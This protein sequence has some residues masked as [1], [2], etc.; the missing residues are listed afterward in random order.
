[1]PT[2]N[3]NGIEIYY[4]RHGDRGEPLVLVHGYTGDITDWRHQLPEFSKTHRVLIMDHRGHGRSHAPVDR[5]QY[6]IENM[7]SDVEALIEHAGF[8]RYH[9]LGHSMGG[10]IAQEIAVGS[11][12]RLMSLTLHDTGYRFGLNRNEMVQKWIAK[13]HQV[14][15][16]H[17]MAAVADLPSVLPTP[18]HVTAQRKQEEKER[19]SRMSRD[20]F[21]G[22]WNALGA[23]SG[24]EDRVHHIT[25][26]T[27]V[28]YGALDAPFVEPAKWFA[29]KIPNA[30]IEVVPEAG[31]SPQFERPDL[32][33]AALRRHLERNAAAPSK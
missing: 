6:T 16:E 20:A 31:H 12:A 9:L 25:A 8:E 3:I 7:V 17:G 26:P 30:V 15:E 28:I 19:L 13:R 11:G 27:M 14:A 5:S 4:E 18:P 1:V 32:F 10:A 29:S 23:W 21:I 24:I 2:A 22:A 33:N